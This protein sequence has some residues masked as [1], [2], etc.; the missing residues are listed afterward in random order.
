MATKKI[1]P[2]ALF[3][4]VGT[5]AQADATKV[6]AYFARG[7]Y[8]TYFRRDVA[9]QRDIVEQH[10]K[11]VG[12]GVVIPQRYVDAFKDDTTRI[13][14]SRTLAE[15]LADDTLVPPTV[16]PSSGFSLMSLDIPAEGES[17]GTESTEGTTTDPVTPAAP[18]P[19]AP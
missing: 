9:G 12:G 2:I 17:F 14:D 15:I 16:T 7:G 4:Y 19:P 13:L 10:V 18:P 5:L 6:E 3:F 8:R 1:T 11:I